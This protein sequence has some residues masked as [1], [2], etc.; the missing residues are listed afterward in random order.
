ME[1]KDFWKKETM[2]K[3][4]NPAV[5]TGDQEPFLDRPTKKG[6]YKTWITGQLA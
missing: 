6:E 1:R 3:Q 4:R 5:T 2:Y